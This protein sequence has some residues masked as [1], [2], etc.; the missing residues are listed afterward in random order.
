MIGGGDCGPARE[1]MKY[2]GIQQIDVVEIDPKVTEICRTW[3]TPASC[4]DGETR[5]NMIHRDGIDWIQE[6][7]GVYDV[8]II[9]RPDPVGPGKNYFNLI[10][11]NM[12]T[13]ALRMM[14]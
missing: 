3:L 1:A 14:A 5:L 4:Y 10:F 2:D 11:I 12:S 9:D 8:L 7:K 13:T 6:Q